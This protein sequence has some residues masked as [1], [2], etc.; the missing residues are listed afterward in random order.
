MGYITMQE[1]EQDDHPMSEGEQYSVVG[2][3]VLLL[4][5]LVAMWRRG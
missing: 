2:A 5:F 4:Y 3:T 1:A